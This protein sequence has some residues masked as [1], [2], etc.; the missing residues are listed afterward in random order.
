LSSVIEFCMGR[1]DFYKANPS[2]HSEVLIE[3]LEEVI[4]F[5]DDLTDMT[6]DEMLDTKGDDE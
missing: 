3:E 6:T 5:C 4:A 2:L 1:I